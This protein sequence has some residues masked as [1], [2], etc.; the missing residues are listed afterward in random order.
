MSDRLMRESVERTPCGRC[1]PTEFSP[2]ASARRGNHLD[3]ESPRARL[4]RRS[5]QNDAATPSFP[6]S[7]RRTRTCLWR[8]KLTRAAFENAPEAPGANRPP[9]AASS[10]LRMYG[11]SPLH[12]PRQITAAGTPESSWYTDTSSAAPVQLGTSP[13][14]PPPE[15]SPPP[16]ALV[17]EF[18]GDGGTAFL[19][20]VSSSGRRAFDA[21][22]RTRC[23]EKMRRTRSPEPFLGPSCSRSAS[24]SREPVASFVTP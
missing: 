19:H 13:P 2:V 1:P 14:F 9:R 20:G 16:L 22:S 10:R 17:V 5:G 24:P 6:N 4:N 3:A 11:M 23:P 18:A 12:A 21:T 7:R 8:S 15:A